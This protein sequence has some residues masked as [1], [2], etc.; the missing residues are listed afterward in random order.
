MSEFCMQ[1]QAW[2]FQWLDY[3]NYIKNINKHVVYGIAQG[4]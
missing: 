2:I 4:K 1:A 3:C